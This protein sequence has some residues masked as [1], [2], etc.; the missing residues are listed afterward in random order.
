[1]KTPRLALTMLAASIALGVG[2][3]QYGQ[4]LVFSASM[5]IVV[6][7]IW[8][9]T[10]ELTPEAR[11]TL[12]GTAAVV[13]MGYGVGMGLIINGQVYHG[14]TGAAAEFG[15][16]NHLPGGKD[17]TQ[18]AIGGFSETANEGVGFGLGFA[19]PGWD[20]LLKHLGGDALQ[21]KALIDAG[22]LIEKNFRD[23]RDEF[24]SSASARREFLRALGVEP[25]P[26]DLCISLF[27]YSQRGFGSA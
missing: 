1:M 6:F 4:E 7:L 25:K 15:H 13:F 3:F 17:L 11:A 21:Q 23:A 20:N 19:P 5:A 18:L 26:G 2:K 16:M 27:C 12:I 9:L 22:L 8:R 14:P 24:N 10:R